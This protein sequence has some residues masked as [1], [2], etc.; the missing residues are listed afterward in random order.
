ML[1]SSPLRRPR[2]ATLPAT[3]LNRAARSTRACAL[4]DGQ[5]ALAERD[6]R[7]SAKKRVTES[8]P[9]L[10]MRDAS[11]TLID[12]TAFTRSVLASGTAA[13][14]ARFIAVTRSSTR[15]CCPAKRSSFAPSSRKPAAGCAPWVAEEA[16]GAAEQP[17]RRD[18]PSLERRADADDRVGVAGLGRAGD[19]RRDRSEPARR[20]NS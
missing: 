15:C 14:A 8:S 2:F 17:Y 7:L 9:P 3:A 19:A 18:R 20:A 5:E 1:A 11:L 12:L 10:T 16:I 4:D 13:S 6:A